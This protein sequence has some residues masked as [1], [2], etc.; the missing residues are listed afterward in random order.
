MPHNSNDFHSLA[1]VESAIAELENHDVL[2]L[3]LY[4]G[5]NLVFNDREFSED[6]LINEAVS[7]TL[8]G[9]RQW[10]Q[11]LTIVQHLIGSMRSIANGQR[12]KKGSHAEL[13]SEDLSYDD[14]QIQLESESEHCIDNATVNDSQTAIKT[15]FATFE[16]DS[17]STKI[18]NALL[19]DEK[20]S[21]TISKTS[22][23]ENRYGAARKRITRKVLMMRKGGQI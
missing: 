20:R 16:K 13:L 8:S 5:A 15:I 17:D 6:D 14:K 19:N 7:R 10:N 11:K 18:L 21:E 22:M 9:N 4:A 23:S 2:K 3:R 1:E 12:R